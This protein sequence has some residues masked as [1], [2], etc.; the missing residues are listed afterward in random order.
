MSDHLNAGETLAPNQAVDST[1]N[2][3]ALLLQSDSNLVLYERVPQGRPRA[4]W[5]SN[6]VGRGAVRCAM[7][8]DGNLVLYDADERAV[9]ASNT[10]GNPGSRLDVQVDGNLVIYRA[11]GVPIW[12]TNTVQRARSAG[13]DASSFD[14]ILGARPADMPRFASS[15]EIGSPEAAARVGDWALGLALRSLERALR[16]AEAPDT[17]SLSENPHAA[18]RLLVDAMGRHAVSP[19]TVRARMQRAPDALRAVMASTAPVAAEPMTIHV[20]P[21]VVPRPLAADPPAA[22]GEGVGRTASALTTQDRAWIRVT[23]VECIRETPPKGGADDVLA[24]LIAAGP[25]GAVAMTSPTYIG[26]YDSGTNHDYSGDPLD[27]TFPPVSVYLSVPSISLGSVL[28]VTV[29]LYDDDSINSFWTELMGLVHQI[30][31]VAVEAYVYYET[32]DPELAESARQLADWSGRHI[33]DAIQKSFADTDVI[34]VATATWRY[35]GTSVVSP[36]PVDVFPRRVPGA[37]PDPEKAFYRVFFKV[38]HTVDPKTPRVVDP[39]SATLVMPTSGPPFEVTLVDAGPWSALAVGRDPTDARGRPLV[40]ALDR[41]GALWFFRGYGPPWTRVNGPPMDRVAN[42]WALDAEGALYSVADGALTRE[43]GRQ[44]RVSVG[45]DGAVWCLDAS[46]RIWVRRPGPEPMNIRAR[47]RQVPGVLRAI[48]VV[49]QKNVWGVNPQGQTLHWDGIVFT[50]TTS[51][52]GSV[53]ALSASAQS[54]AAVDEGGQTW[55]ATPASPTWSVCPIVSVREGH[56]ETLIV[57]DLAVAP[58]PHDGSDDVLFVLDD[59]GRI[60]LHRSVVR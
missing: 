56:R 7:Q 32:G 29:S 35:D 13:S 26:D 46:Q 31:L 47:W 11:D 60:H 20:A 14:V 9:W 8:H 55:F 15:A 41:A 57:R 34:G 23:R 39:N 4:L 40:W 59:R 52:I 45:V 49:D 37:P 44:R 18:E 54:L 21:S 16:H 58:K 5:A 28:R 38:V 33:A 2:A 6:T 53:R 1:D 50:P 17:E 25:S 3:Y 30:G 24:G 12:A 42:G 43:S 10:E 27:V 22:G 48:A 19:A 51:V 36:P